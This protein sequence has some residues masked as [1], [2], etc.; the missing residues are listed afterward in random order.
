LIA[1]ILPWREVEVGREW[2]R[3]IA[4]ELGSGVSVFLGRCIQ[5]KKR[6]WNPKG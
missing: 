2:E 4:S 3:E 5:T 1:L 6:K